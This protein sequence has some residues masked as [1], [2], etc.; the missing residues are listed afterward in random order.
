[1]EQLKFSS[2][3]ELYNRVRPALDC[4]AH[5]LKRY[6][7]NYISTTD[8]WNALKNLKWARENN[9]SLDK[10]VDDILNTNNSFF[11]EYVKNTIKDMPKSVNLDDENLL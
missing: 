6:G 2:V 5:E 3:S 7:Y 10:I 9:L 8:I 11:D 1:M 4:K